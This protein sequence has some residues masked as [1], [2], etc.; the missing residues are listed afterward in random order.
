MCEEDEGLEDIEIARC[1]REQGVQMGKSLDEH[2]REL[3][4][5]LTFVEHFS[6]KFPAWLKFYA[7]NPLQ[8]VSYFLIFLN[9]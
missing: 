2:N 4:H 6:G 8:S 1:L 5:P 7:E 3:F 9:N